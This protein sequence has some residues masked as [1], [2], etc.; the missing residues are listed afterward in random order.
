L[1]NFEN[2]ENVAAINGATI[3]TIVAENGVIVEV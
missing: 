1:K 3:Q 2:T